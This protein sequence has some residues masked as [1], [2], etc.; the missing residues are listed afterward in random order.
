MYY[1]YGDKNESQRTVYPEG[2]ISLPKGCYDFYP[3]TRCGTDEQNIWSYGNAHRM[4]YVYDQPTISKDAGTYD[5]KIEVEI[6]N[7]PESG[8]YSASVYYYF[9]DDEEHA[10][11]YTSGSKITINESKTLNVYIYVEGDSG[12]THKT[13]IIERQYVIRQNAGLAYTQNNES[14]E[15]ADYTI[16]GSNNAALPTLQN[17]NNVAVTYTSSKETVATVNEEG[18]VTPV[19]VGETTI[20][21]ASAQTATLQAGEASYTLKVYKDLNHESITVSVANATY[22]GSEVEPDVTVKDGTTDVTAYFT[23]SYSDNVQVGTNAKVTIV[24]NNDL[25]VN[26]YVGSRT[27]TFAIDNRTLEVGKDVNFAS[28]QKWASFYTTTENLELPDGVMAYVVTGVANSAVSVKAI[29]YVPK[30]V[31]VL[32]E[33]E[34]TTTTDNA[35]AEGNL[36]QGTAES[37]AV[38]GIEGNVYVLYNGGFTR[39]TSG[40]IPAGR[41]YL[42]LE[43]NAGARLSIFEDDATGIGSVANNQQLKGNEQYYDL[44]GRKVESHA[45]KGL[46]I[47]N[48][49]KVVVK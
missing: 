44:Q 49:R 18:V 4:M 48:G 10:V 23:F 7:L 5:D 37:T 35:S 42:V 15:V 28:G 45:K 9:D 12:K 24:P 34:S 13:E 32:I 30:N 11:Q 29:N 36:L 31:P 46:Y 40:A 14:V 47:K 26:F 25:E 17:E 2:G 6:T 3:Y 39:A 33:N 22:T 19:G 41:A 20:T 38:S 21:A 8:Y 43:Q 1:S 27:E 16:G